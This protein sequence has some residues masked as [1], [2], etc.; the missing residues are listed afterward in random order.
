MSTI[1]NFN[2]LDLNATYTYADYLKW[3]FEERLKL[4]RGKIF[5]MSP[6]PNRYHQEIS[7]NFVF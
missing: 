5:K 1:T 6:A 3:E 7:G 4:F 2:D